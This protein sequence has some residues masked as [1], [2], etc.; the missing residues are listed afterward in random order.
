MVVWRYS[1]TQEVEAGGSW[2]QF[3]PRLH[4]ETLS[5]KKKINVI[6]YSIPEKKNIS[7]GEESERAEIVH[8]E[9]LTAVC[10]VWV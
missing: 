10:Y 3:K 4:C 9:N 2:V 5:G 6:I 8:T 7:S 1:S